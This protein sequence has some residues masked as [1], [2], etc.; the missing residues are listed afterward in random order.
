M[1]LRLEPLAL[2][3]RFAFRIAHGSKQEHRNTLVRIEHD[4]VEGL[5]EASPAHYYGETSATVALALETWAPHLGDDP[6]ALDAI[7]A[8]FDGV[9]QGHRA[10][11]A[12]IEMALHDWIG[13]KLG[14]PVWR[15]LGLEPGHVP[16]SAVTLG[17]APR[18]EMEEKLATVADFP[19]LKVKLGSP[20]DVENLRFI[21]S[22][23]A[24]R[25]QVDANA[26]WAAHDAVRMLTAIAPLG[27]DLVEQP[28]A[29]EDLD[30]LSFVRARSPIPIFADESVHHLHDIA[31]LAGRVD[32]VNLKLMKTGGVR[33]ML[34]MIHAARAHGMKVML[35]CMVESSLA[36][37][38]AAQLAPLADMLDLDGHWLLDC[39]PFVGAPGERGEIRLSDVPGLGV[40]RAE[41]SP[42]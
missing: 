25:L 30:G 39:D 14:I 4:G 40:R 18:A 11:R 17:M 23:Y 2:R 34:R 33:E 42:A 21:R 29:R 28:V 12:A 16:P 5:G 3:T 22:R 24:G 31:K 35:G 19:I 41:A 10:A 9:L 20:G 26:S 13:K 15:L 38:A 32:G 6:F 7:G 36:L 8:R 37:S 27:I 1:Q